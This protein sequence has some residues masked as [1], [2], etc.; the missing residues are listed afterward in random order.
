MAG[1][2]NNIQ[3][4]KYLIWHLQHFVLVPDIKD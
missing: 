1:K 2:A 3:Q 4:K